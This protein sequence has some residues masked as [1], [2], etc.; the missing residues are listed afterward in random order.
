[1]NDYFDTED[2]WASWA[3]RNPATLTAALT[4]SAVSTDSALE[5]EVLRFSGILGADSGEVRG[6]LY[7]LRDAMRCAHLA[8]EGA[9]V[10]ID[11]Q[12]AVQAALDNGL[13]E[14]V[15]YAT[16]DT[17]IDAYVT[18]AEAGAGGPLFGLREKLHLLRGEEAAERLRAQM[19]YTRIDSRDP[20][21]PTALQETERRVFVG[22]AFGGPVSVHAADP[23]PSI[24]N[25][26][27]SADFVEPGE[28]G[29]RFAYGYHVP[30]PA[31]VA[32]R[33]ANV[34]ESAAERRRIDELKATI[35]VG[36]L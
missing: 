21:C 4:I 16:T 11:E 19:D 32:P 34:H 31:T 35:S 5:Q 3:Y 36:D 33:I 17:E 2:A 24:G 18:A 25:V 12:L 20:F 22:G 26:G 8:A 9:A 27:E 28:A 10:R 29:C 13:G 6:A 30:D 23:A 14:L 1:M 15:T 7:A